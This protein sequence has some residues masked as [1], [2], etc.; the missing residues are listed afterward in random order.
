ML[1][2]QLSGERLRFYAAVCLALFFIASNNAAAQ[3]SG[4]GV[5]LRQAISKTLAQNPQ[6]HQFNIKKEASLGRREQ[7]ELAPALTLSLEVEN[8]AGSGDLNGFDSAETTVALSSVIELGGKRNARMSVA[9]AQ[10]QTLEHHRQAFT[11]DVLGELTR[12]FIQALEVRALFELANEARDLAQNTLAIVKNRSLQG[13][14]PEYEVKRAKSLLAHTQLRVDALKKQHERLRIKIAAYW[15][16]T[17]PSW[18]KFNGDIF[19]YGTA[20]DFSALYQRALAS[21]AIAQF[22]SEARLKKAEVSLAKTYST[23]DL[24]WQV[25]VRRFEES[26]D[27]AF[28]AGVSIPLFGNK[29][30]RGALKSAMAFENEIIYERQT[31]LLKLHVQL[32]EAY[33]Q[34]QQH[35]AAVNVFRT[36][37]LPDLNAVLDST[38]RAYETG[39]YSYQDWIAAQKELLDAK[40]SLIESAAAASLNQAVIEQ[41]IA[42]PLN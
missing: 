21:P 12:T 35:I 7:S 2:I 31:A 36:T 34:R 40:R 11:L 18:D 17:S 15:G 26:G 10:L 20:L 41:L 3:S 25:G 29:R 24:G 30:N 22:A 28:T 5:S 8:I 27:T 38:Q 42:E 23:S 1:F 33:S 39:R 16:E 9:D 4:T 14:T 32:F 19:T 13:A 37:I 6:L